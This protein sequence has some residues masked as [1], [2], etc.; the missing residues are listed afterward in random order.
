MY[1]QVF[2]VRL[3]LLFLG[4]GAFRTLA[5]HLLLLA[6]LLL[7]QLGVRDV[8]VLDLRGERVL[9]RM[10]RIFYRVLGFFAK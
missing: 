6:E 2:C 3:Q 7:L 8:L 1:L 5:V 9:D 4:S 10:R